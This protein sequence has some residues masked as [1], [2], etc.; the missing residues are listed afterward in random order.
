VTEG[1]AY[2]EA[3]H[4]ALG[5]SQGR[6]IEK[7]SLVKKGNTVAS[8][9]WQDR[10]VCFAPDVIFFWV[11]P[12]A[13]RILLGDVNIGIPVLFNSEDEMQIYNRINTDQQQQALPRLCR[14]VRDLL[15]DPTHWAIIKTIAE[16]FLSESAKRDCIPGEEA[17]SFFESALGRTPGE[18]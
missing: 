12:M 14:I 13:E 17:Q 5:V 8:T 11:G 15:I 4:A 6:T 3:A 16:W 7:V 2:H 1:T 9:Q 10:P 18:R